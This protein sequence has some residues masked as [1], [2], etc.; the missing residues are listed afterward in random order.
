ME[1]DKLILEFI[2]KSKE[3]R[4]AKTLAAPAAGDGGVGSGDSPTRY[5]TTYNTLII[6]RVILNQWAE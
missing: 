2:W 1:I 4:I 6:K 5:Q 3:P